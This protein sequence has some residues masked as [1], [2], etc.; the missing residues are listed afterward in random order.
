MNHR[1]LARAISDI[2]APSRGRTR[3]SLEVSRRSGEHETEEGEKVRV[4]ASSTEL[5]YF[6]GQA[7][8]A[9]ARLRYD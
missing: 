2:L 5:F 7:L 1:P 3:P 6:Y 8:E 4:L 9:G